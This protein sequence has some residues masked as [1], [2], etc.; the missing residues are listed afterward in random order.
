MSPRR[1]RVIVWRRDGTGTAP[2]G[3]IYALDS[4]QTRGEPRMYSVLWYPHPQRGPEIVP[5]VHSSGWPTKDRAIQDA[6]EHYRARTE[7]SR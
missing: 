4:E 3:T 1:R 5:P 6:E 2:D 7:T